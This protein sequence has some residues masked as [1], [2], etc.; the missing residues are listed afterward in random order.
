[1]PPKKKTRTEDTNPIYTGDEVQLL[2]ESIQSTKSKYFCE[3]GIVFIHP[4]SVG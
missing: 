4:F 3:N 1:M 2:L